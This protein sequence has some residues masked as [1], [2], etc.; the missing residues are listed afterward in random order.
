MFRKNTLQGF[1]E[2]NPTGDYGKL[3]DDAFADSIIP[4]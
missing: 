3:S 1:T 4:F 2:L